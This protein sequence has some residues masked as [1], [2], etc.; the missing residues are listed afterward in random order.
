MIRVNVVSVLNLNPQ[1]IHEEFLEI[2]QVLKLAMDLGTPHPQAPKEYTL[3]KG[4]VE[5]FFDKLGY[6]SARYVMLAEQHYHNLKRRGEEPDFRMDD[7]LA[8][9]SEAHHKAPHLFNNYQ[10]PIQAQI[11]NWEQLQVWA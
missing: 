11:M 5:F 10:P 1:Q 6:I 8:E 7:I 2:R 4:H 9:V 3:L